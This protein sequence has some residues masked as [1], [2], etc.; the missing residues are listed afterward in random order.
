MFGF[1]S[2]T[3][4]RERKLPQSQSLIGLNGASW[5]LIQTVWSERRWWRDGCL[6]SK[7]VSKSVTPWYFGGRPSSWRLNVGMHCFALNK[8]VLCVPVSYGWLGS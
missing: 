3:R 1:G 7:E 5:G 2:P 8:L 4:T 6:G